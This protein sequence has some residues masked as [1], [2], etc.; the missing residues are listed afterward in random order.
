MAIMS[1]LLYRGPL[2]KE[3]KEKANCTV[4]PDRTSKATGLLVLPRKAQKEEKYR[5]G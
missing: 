5:G 4:V 1:Q 3:K 2:K